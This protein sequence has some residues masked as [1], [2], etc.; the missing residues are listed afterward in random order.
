MADKEAPQ[1]VEAEQQAAEQPDTQEEQSEAELMARLQEDFEAAQ[2]AL[3]EAE[4]QVL[5]AKADAQNVR[6]RAEQD[7]AKAHKF[8]LEK[9]V[10]ELLPVVDS[11]DR[12]IEACPEGDASADAIRQGVEMTLTMFTAAL[13]K[14]AVE[15][16]NP[17]GEP[18][19]PQLHQAMS[20]VE[21]ADV[22]PNT[23]L[24]VMQKGYLLNERLVRPA[25]VVVS[26]AAPGNA[27]KIDAK[28]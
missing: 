14:F 28:A 27:G 20:M 25:M 4:D 17:E 22:E 13:K 18:F 11:L 21:N 2:A 6:R 26:K 24:A 19:D 7:V 15:A 3:S 12:A 16:V 8:A 10:N 5:R 23:V 9:F 1:E